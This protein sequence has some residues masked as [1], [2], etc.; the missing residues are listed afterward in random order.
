[1]LATTNLYQ[2]YS[3]LYSFV[4]DNPAHFIEL[5]IGLTVIIFTIVDFPAPFGPN[6]P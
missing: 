4:N 2:I 6:S 3:F 5:T 1:M